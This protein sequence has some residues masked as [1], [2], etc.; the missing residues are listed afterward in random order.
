[1]EFRARLYSLGRKPRRG[2]GLHAGDGVTEVKG[3]DLRREALP[4]S[5]TQGKI[6][7]PERGTGPLY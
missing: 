7:F 6:K 3:A 4:G 5:M 1:M 2:R